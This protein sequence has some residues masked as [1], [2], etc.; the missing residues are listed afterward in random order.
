MSYFVTPVI[1]PQN[2]GSKQSPPQSSTTASLSE[3]QSAFSE[4]FLDG[5]KQMLKSDGLLNLEILLMQNRCRIKS[6]KITSAKS[7]IIM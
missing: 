6:T 4:N 2:N 7:L 5:E 1:G 3:C